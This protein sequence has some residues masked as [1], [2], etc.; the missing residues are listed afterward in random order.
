MIVT[1]IL[2]LVVLYGASI[3]LFYKQA[4]KYISPC[5]QKFLFYQVKLYF[6]FHGFCF[7]KCDFE[8]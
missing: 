5:T 6:L 8:L 4:I 2:P 7:T 1:L 3:N